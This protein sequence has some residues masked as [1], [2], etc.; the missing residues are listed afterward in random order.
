MDAANP[1]E[2][3]RGF[4]S[5]KG[6]VDFVLCFPDSTLYNSATIKPLILASLE[7][8][9]PIVGFSPNFVRAGAA[10]GVYPDFR[11]IGRQAGRVARGCGSTC[12]GTE[13]TARVLNVAVNQRVERL[14]GLEHDPAA[15][16]V[17]IR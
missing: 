9:L 7:H 6:K 3:L 1:E 10:A 4:A 5:L 13:E 12:P 14:L 17:T 2:L 15:R 11:E 8:R 16:V